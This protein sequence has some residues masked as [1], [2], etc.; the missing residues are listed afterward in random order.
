M[1]YDDYLA[2]EEDSFFW[3]DKKSDSTTGVAGLIAL[4]ITLLI[5]LVFF[6]IRR[7]DVTNGL[8][9]SGIFQLLN[10]DKEWDPRLRLLLFIGMVILSVV[11]QR[12]S[13]IASLL[14]ALFS[15][16]CVA[17][18][19]GIWQ[20]YDSQATQYMVMGICFAVTALLNFASWIQRS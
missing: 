5:H 3:N 2:Y 19:G 18:L 4:P 13:K 9:V 10:L 8:L 16:A 11:V 17:I 1:T 14:F 15:C 20:H 7:F 6:L 12:V